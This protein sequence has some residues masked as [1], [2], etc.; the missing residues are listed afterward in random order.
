MLLL[1]LLF[2]LPVTNILSKKEKGFVD[3][4][5]RVVIVWGAQGD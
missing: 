1:M 2:S 4:E 5:N 3:M